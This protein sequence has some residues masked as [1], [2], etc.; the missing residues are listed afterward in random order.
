MSRGSDAENPDLEFVFTT[1][2]GTVNLRGDDDFAAD[3]TLSGG[4]V[5]TL[6]I[7]ARGSEITRLVANGKDY[8]HLTDIFEI[9]DDA[10]S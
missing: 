9:M 1:M 10:G 3:L 6:E 4:E 8:G 2:S 5:E 7:T